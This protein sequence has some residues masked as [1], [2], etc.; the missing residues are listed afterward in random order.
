MSSLTQRVRKSP[1]LGTARDLLL[2][3]ARSDALPLVLLALLVIV[4]FY[5]IVFLGKTLQTSSFLWGTLGARPPFG[6]P[7]TPDYNT[8]ILDPLATAVSS[9]PMAEKLSRTIRDFEL[10]LWN[11]D[12]AMGRPL[13]ASYSAELTNPLRLPVA[14]WPSPEMWDAYLLARFWIAGAFTY[15]LARHMGMGRSGGLGAGAAYILSGYFMLYV[16]TPHVDYAMMVPVLL[17]SFELL[18]KRATPLRLVFASAAIAVMILVDNPEAAAIGLLFGTAF[19]LFRV[20]PAVLAN[21]AAAVPKLGLFSLAALTGGG[22]TAVVLIPF[23]EFSGSLGI[24][25]YSLHRHTSDLGIGTLHTPLRHMISLFIPYFNGMPVDNFQHDGLSGVRNYVSV[26][27][28]LLALLAIT[29][30]RR[31]SHPIWFFAAA[32]AFFVAKTYGVPVVNS[33]G[34]LP[35]LNVIDFGL[36]SGPA[37]SLSVAILAGWG[38]QRLRDGE[39]TR[40]HLFA[41]GA[42]VAILLAWL[43]WLNRDLLDT[44]PKSHL[45]FWIAAPASLVCLI[46]ALYLL[47]ERRLITPRALAVVA[48]LALALEMSLP[49]LV[50]HDEL[51]ALTRETATRHLATIERPQR[52]DPASKPP[53]IE[54]LESDSSVYRVFGL[55]RVLYPNYSEAFGIADIRGFTAQSVERYFVYIRN[56]IQPSM[57]SRFTGAYLPPLN[58]ERDPPDIVGNPLFDLTNVRYVMTRGGRDILDALGDST[59]EE[60]VAQQFTLVYEGEVNVYENLRAMPRAFLVGDVN[61]VPDLETAKDLMSDPSF[62]PRQTAIVETPTSDDTLL[63]LID[64][65]PPALSEVS[66]EEYSANTVRLSVRTDEPAL[67]VLADTNYPGWRVTV[68]GESETL[69]ATDVAFRGVFIPSGTHTVEFTYLPA[70]FVAGGAISVASIAIVGSFALAW[71]VIARR[72]LTGKNQTSSI[73]AK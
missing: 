33:V 69:Y 29:R 22:M 71:G 72:R 4:V 57:R 64:G 43:V 21:H 7:E 27:P 58:S 25:G 38:L 15:G 40:Y 17:F 54:F 36:Y 41:C 46:A 20:A 67:L 3:F 23:L 45:L 1:N 60:E 16:N 39:L 34:E 37:I 24:G 13:L 18:Q 11:T 49:T 63:A 66:F 50:F 26:V 10:P 61:T 14:I 53:Y 56:F 12:T 68:D 31:W 47:A 30:R 32:G 59:T 51:G 19:Y 65:E 8:Y 35:L 48:V 6:F 28:V 44:I 70:S 73:D 42:L 2:T 5:D 62:D 9:E 52:H 55:D